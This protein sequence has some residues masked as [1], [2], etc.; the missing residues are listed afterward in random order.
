M[1]AV[2]QMLRYLFQVEQSH[3]VEKAKIYENFFQSP[4]VERFCDAMGIEPGTHES[5]KHRCP[6]L[7]NILESCGVLEQEASH[8][9]L[10]KLA[11]SADLLVPEGGDILE[12][13][14]IASVLVKHGIQSPST[15]SPEQVDGLQALFGK[16]FLSSSY[17]LSET[18]EIPE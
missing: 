13:K 8:V 16:T 1:P 10:L 7:L 6:L 11:I 2:R 4:S 18:L 12:G 15:L 3:I 14:E 9:R 17:P 5:A